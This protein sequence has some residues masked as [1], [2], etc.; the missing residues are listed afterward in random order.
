MNIQWYPG[1][2]AKAKRLVTENL[3]LVDVV[4]ELLDARIPIAS[5][6]PDIAELAKN[7]R[8]IIALNKADLADDKQNKAWQSYFESQGLAVCLCNSKQG[9]GLS[10]I[11]VLARKLMKDK[12]DRQKARGRLFVPIRAMVVG[13][14]NVGKSTLI[15]KYVKKN[16]AAASDRPGVTKGKQWIKILKD[17]ELLDTP[18]I[19]WHKF[20]DPQVGLHLAFTGAI[21]DEIMD[22]IT[23]AEELAGAIMSIDP[24][25]INIRYN[26]NLTMETDKREA[27]TSIGKARGFLIKG[28]EIDLN[29]TAIIFI[30]EFRGGKLGQ[31]T[32][33]KPVLNN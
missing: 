11:S 23:L 17:F 7:K 27:L 15:N 19:L 16:V 9:D 10:D 22:R 32:L 12:I 20:D 25:A 13:I 33:E 1:H 30:D 3:A 14:P 4:I 6:N 26:T 5:Q 21:N 24:S 29:R 18:G 2:M 28:G 31:I 8:R